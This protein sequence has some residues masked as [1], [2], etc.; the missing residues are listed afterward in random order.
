MRSARTPTVFHVWR[1]NGWTV[2]TVAGD[3]DSIGIQELERQ[4]ASAA[5]NGVFV[6]VDLSHATVLDESF[7]DVLTGMDRLLRAFGGRLTVLG[8]CCMSP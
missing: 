2:L 1:W 4:F 8:R 3:L 7:D 5:G 6:A